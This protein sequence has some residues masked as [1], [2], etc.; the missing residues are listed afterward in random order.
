[1]STP[2]QAPE[3]V[4]DLIPEVKERIQRGAYDFVNCATRLNHLGPLHKMDVMAA[5]MVTRGDFAAMAD[6]LGRRRHAVKNFVYRNRDI[7]LFWT[8]TR[9]AVIDKI[10]QNAI[11]AALEDDRGMMK[12]F[13][14]T[15]GKD[16]G[17]SQRSEHTGQGGG[18]I[19]VE[20]APPREQLRNVLERL[21]KAQT[22]AE[23]I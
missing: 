14:Q 12:F 19:G 13:L 5:I 10:E 8:D 3:H 2:P 15:L 18:P 16:R 22:P 17:Y 1:M 9:E 11:D 21:G 23:S 7:L 20:S 6:L 4:E